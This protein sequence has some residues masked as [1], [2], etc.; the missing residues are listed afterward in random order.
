MGELVF[1]LAEGVASEK[2]IRRCNSKLNQTRNRAQDAIDCGKFSGDLLKQVQDWLAVLESLSVPGENS[3][4]QLLVS[5]ENTRR[6]WT[7]RSCL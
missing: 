2:Q 6:A 7:R 1:A 5:K 3:N 4:A